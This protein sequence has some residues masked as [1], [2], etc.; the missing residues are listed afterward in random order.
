MASFCSLTIGS[1][2]KVLF[3][4]QAWAM[5]S[6]MNISLKTTITQT[7]G[8]KCNLQEQYSCLHVAIEMAQKLVM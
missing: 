3:S 1:H 4:N 8:T 2:H 5:L 7:N 6:E